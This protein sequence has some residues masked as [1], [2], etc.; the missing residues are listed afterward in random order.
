M[1][2]SNML[3]NWNP[4]HCKVS[5]DKQLRRLSRKPQRKAV[6][7]AMNLLRKQMA[8]AIAEAHHA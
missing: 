2:S 6:R 8:E 4:R 7:R 3:D 1:R 5:V